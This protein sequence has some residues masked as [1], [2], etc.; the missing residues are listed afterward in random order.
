GIGTSTPTAKLH[1]SGPLQVESNITLNNGSWIG[2]NEF[3]SLLFPA[4]QDNMILREYGNIMFTPGWRNNDTTAKMILRGDGN[5]GIGTLTPTAKLDVS[6]GSI[7]ISSD[8]HGIDFFG[9]AKIYKKSGSGLKIKPHTDAEGI[10]FLKADGTTSI[11]KIV[12]DRIG[13]GT[14]TPTAK[15]HV[16]GSLQVDETIRLGLDREISFEGNGKIRA[17]SDNHALLFRASENILEIREWGD[18]LLTAGCGGSTPSVPKMVVTSDGNVGIGTT[19]PEQ[20]LHVQGKIRLSDVPVWDGPSEY[21]LTW[22]GVQKNAGNSVWTDKYHCIARE[23]SSRRYKKNIIPL[24]D[25]FMKLLSLEPH[26]YQMREG[27]G[28]PGFWSFGYLAED[29]D[30]LG[31]KTLVTYNEAGQPE[32]I[33]YKK[34]CVYLNEILKG[35]QEC[36]IKLESQLRELSQVINPSPQKGKSVDNE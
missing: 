34:I 1:V 2:V 4:G 3:H 16:G 18:I 36:L 33:N 29:L 28:T 30:Q 15:L 20:K 7:K 5:L 27:Y 21:D 19:T 11:M 26:Q 23:S 6:S 35:Q 8:D 10:E 22:V 25:D 31:L 17:R 32:G 9:G 12:G 14:I 13:I 24:E